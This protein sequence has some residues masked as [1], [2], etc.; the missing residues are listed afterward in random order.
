MPA[1]TYQDEALTRE[2][3]AAVAIVYD[4]SDWAAMARDSARA[5]ALDTASARHLSSAFGV[6]RIAALFCSGD[7]ISYWFGRAVDSPPGVAA[8]ASIGVIADPV[9]VVRAP[10]LILVDAANPLAG[11][12]FYVDPASAAMVA[13]RNANPPN[14][15]LT[16]VANTPQSYWLDQA[17][18]PAT[19]GGTVARYT[20]AAQAAG[21]MPVLTLYGIPIATAVATH[22][23]GSRRALITAGGSTLSHPAWAHRRRRSSS[24]PMRWPWPT[25]CRLTSAR[26]V[27][28]WC[29]TPSTR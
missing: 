29:A 16:S 15:E 13:A 14:A 3:T 27:S 6:C 17:F 7:V 23:V 22:P 11:K 2:G 1:S 19:V 25:A 24:N 12:P 21:A 28:T 20:G 10:A 5:P 9:R 8:V 4:A 26:N 18:P